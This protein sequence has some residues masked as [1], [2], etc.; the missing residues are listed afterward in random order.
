MCVWGPCGAGEDADISQSRCVVRGQ[1]EGLEEL[2]APAFVQPQIVEE[3]APPPPEERNALAEKAGEDF[4]ADPA[5]R[6]NVEAERTLQIR[7]A[8][9]TWL[10]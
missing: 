5:E 7:D 10:K 9:V 3:V 2:Q 8:C 1:E 6:P 4:P